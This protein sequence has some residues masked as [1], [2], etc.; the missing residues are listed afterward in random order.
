[1]NAVDE[2]LNRAG[3]G[4]VLSGAVA[5][6]G[7]EAGALVTLA[8]RAPRILRVAGTSSGALNA[9]IAAAG[10]ATGRLDRAAEVLEKLWIDDG[11]WQHIAKVNLADW[12]HWRGAFDTGKLQ[13]L[14]MQGLRTVVGDWNGPPVSASGFALTLVTT[15]L[16]A[17]PRRT[18]TVPLPTYEQPIAFTAQDL[19][20]SKNWAR[21]ASAAAASATFP[22]LFSP[23]RFEGAPCIDGGAVNNSPIAYVLATPQVDTVVVVTTESPQVPAL[24]DPGGLALVARVATAVINERIAY[25]LTQA[26]KDNARYAAVVEALASVPPAT[27]NAVV[28]AMGYR[29]LAL[30][31]VQPEGALP[32]DAFSGFLSKDERTQYIEAGKRAPMVKIC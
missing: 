6:G 31:L 9:V 5:Q 21:L 18:G 14:V 19:L 30:Y 12:L 11:S 29:P 13:E 28:G 16:N 17:L 32:G 10:V 20:D 26:Q 23:T 25:D 15:N 4:L 22:G 24:A 2:P 3:V 7:F 1:M 8:A 27:R